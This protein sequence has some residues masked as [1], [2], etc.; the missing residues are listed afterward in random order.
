MSDDL[1]PWDQDFADSLIG[2]TVLVGYTW[3]E[4]AG[5]RREQFLGTVESVDEH[6]GIALR[7]ASGIRWLAPHL[8]AFREAK[9]GDYELISTGEIVSDP[10]YLVTW[11]VHP[12]PS[13]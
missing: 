3:V 1:P 8:N 6:H 5:E 13:G 11:M 9:P 2:A 7:C 10:E 4:P 12:R